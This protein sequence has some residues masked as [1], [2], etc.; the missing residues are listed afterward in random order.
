MDLLDDFQAPGGR[1]ESEGDRVA[2]RL[3]DGIQLGHYR[4]GTRLVE[5]SLATKFNVSHIPVREALARLAEEGLV[6]RLPRRGARV[7]GLSPEL[8]EKVSDVRVL[9]ER[10]V[11]RR[12]HERLTPVHRKTLEQIVDAMV[13]AARDGDIDRVLEL[14][15]RFHEQLVAVADHTILSE[16]V[17]QLR[18]RVNA[19][20][21][22]ATS[23]L[24]GRRLIAHAESH[25][26]LLAAIADGPPGRAEREA[27][28]H[29]RVAARRVHRRLSVD[30]AR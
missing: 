18:G 21:Q 25:R 3:R 5:R 15:R 29:I 12:A 16:L 9:L 2:E 4:P 26:R 11:A 27:E 20:L 19:F 28:R 1:P 6:Q 7:A 23:S 17:V 8:F 30:G 14:D 13:S 22:A 10:F 24:S